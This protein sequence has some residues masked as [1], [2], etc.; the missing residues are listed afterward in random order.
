[1]AQ[2]THEVLIQAPV[3]EVFAYAHD[4]RHWAEWFVGLSGPDSLSG[5]PAAGTTGRFHY[6]MAG[7]RFPLTLTIADDRIDARG[8]LCTV[9]IDGAFTGTQVV[10]YGP[11]DGGT[12]VTFD[13][14]YTPPGQLLGKIA[15]LFVVE[16][17][18]EHALAQSLTNLKVRVEAMART[19]T[20]APTSPAG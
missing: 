2:L 14:D 4:P 9:L 8:A 5:G 18:Q 12:L 1:M 17:M 3:A 6:L 13:V 20:A 10:T 11:K 16:R 15:D 7:I 19:R